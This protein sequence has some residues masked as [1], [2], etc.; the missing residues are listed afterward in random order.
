[1]WLHQVIMQSGE[2]SFPTK[3]SGNNDW[4]WDHRRVDSEQEK[5][6]ERKC[7]KNTDPMSEFRV[8]TFRSAHL[9]GGWVVKLRQVQSQFTESC[10]LLLPTLDFRDKIPPFTA[11]KTIKQMD[12]TFLP[13][14]LDIFYHLKS[15]MLNLK[16]VSFH[17]F[18]NAAINSDYQFHPS[19]FSLSTVTSASGNTVT[20][21]K[22]LWSN[23]EKQQRLNGL[24]S[25]IEW[26]GV[27]LCFIVHFWWLLNFLVV[28]GPSFQFL[29]HCDK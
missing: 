15:Y 7:P 11:N 2:L 28:V 27:Q 22:R 23:Q 4:S 21:G 10:R 24:L 17:N 5:V 6:A 3:S 19:P 18:H 26:K 8:G 12:I 29:F 20:S 9:K 13:E 16:V 14:G 1:M 25:G